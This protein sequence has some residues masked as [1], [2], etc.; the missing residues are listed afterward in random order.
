[1][2]NITGG[3]RSTRPYDSAYDELITRAG[4]DGAPQGCAAARSLEVAVGVLAS[5]R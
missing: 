2:A 4:D 1:M 5:E 3:E